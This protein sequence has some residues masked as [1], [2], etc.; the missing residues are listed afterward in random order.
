VAARM[1]DSTTTLARRR[2][3]AEGAEVRGRGGVC[4]DTLMWQGG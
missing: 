4:Q 3:G 1:Y 2:Q